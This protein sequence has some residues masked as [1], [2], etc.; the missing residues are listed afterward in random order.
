MRQIVRA[1]LPLGEGVVLDPFMGGGSTIAAAVAVS[2]QSI[3]VELD[4]RFFRST[5]KAIPAL[6]NWNGNG[7]TNGAQSPSVTQQK[8]ALADQS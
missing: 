8:L 1:S 5:A 4:E 2:Y 7:K 3:G 6:A